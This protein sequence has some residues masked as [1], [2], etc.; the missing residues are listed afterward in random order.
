MSWTT[1]L[2]QERKDGSQDD[3]GGGFFWDPP[4]SKN[5]D[6]KSYNNVREL[7][8]RLCQATVRA[9]E[10]EMELEKYRDIVDKKEEIT[11]GHQ[12][13]ELM[14]TKQDMV[15]RIIQIGEKGR[16]AER[17]MKKLQLDESAFVNDFRAAISKLNS[18]EQINLVRCALNALEL[19]NGACESHDNNEKL[20]IGRKKN[21]ISQYNHIEESANINGVYDKRETEL[22]NKIQKLEEENKSLSVS[23]DELDQQHAQSIEKI[24]TL[25]DELQKKHQCLQVAYETLYV[26]Y[27]AIQEKIKMLENESTK[28][29]ISLEATEQNGTIL[30][31]KLATEDKNNQ[32]EQLTM[33][34]KINQIIK[35]YTDTEVQ[36]EDN[37]EVD[38]NVVLNEIAQKVNEIIKNTHIHL[39]EGETIFEA[40]AKHCIEAEWKIDMLER[41]L[42][43]LSSELR[44]TNEIRDSLQM[45][46]DEQQSTIESLE[47]EIQHMKSNLPSIPEASEE[48]VATLEVETESMAQEIKRLQCEYDTLRNK[49]SELITS[50]SNMEGSLRNQENLEAE[51]R[52]IKQQLEIAQQQLAGASKNVENNENMMED[53]SRRLHSSLDENTELR[54]K[55]DNLESRDKQMQEELNVYIEKCKGL[56]ENLELIEELKL[57]INNVRKELKNSAEN[58]KRLEKELAFADDAKKEIE[59]DILS[60]SQEKEQLEMEFAML[61]KCGSV[62]EDSEILKDL[63]SQLESA[64]REKDDLEYDLMNMR[65]EL[66]LALS[67][68][69]KRD[70][71]CNEL[72]TENE[73][74]IKENNIVLEQMGSVTNEW[75]ERLELLQTE[76]NLLQQEHSIL[77]EEATADKLELAEIR[78][79]TEQLEEKSINIEKNFHASKSECEILKSDCEN[80]RSRANMVTELESELQRMQIIENKLVASANETE[81]LKQKLISLQDESNE[82]TVIREKY[83][84]LKEQ[85]KN[86]RDLEEKLKNSENRCQ[87]LEDQLAVLTSDHQNL[88]TSKLTDE[89][90]QQ[91]RKT[92]EKKMAELELLIEEK[93]QLSEKLIACQR[94]LQS[95]ID[96]SKE[97]A[98][99]AKETI[100]TLSQIIK[101]KDQEI[102][103]VKSTMASDLEQK[104]VINE[105][106]LTSLNVERDELVKL[107]QIKHNESLQYHA[108]IQR[109]TQLFNDQASALQTAVAERESYENLLKQKEA[110]ILWGQNELQVVRQRLKNFE[111][112]MNHG[113]TCNIVEHSIQ[114]SQVAVLNEK[115]NAMEA[116]L[117]K[118]QSSNR[119]LQSQLTDSQQRE[120]AAA[121][122]L[123]RLRSHLVEME[124]NYTEEALLIEQSKKELETKLLQAEETL[125]NSS[126]VY[127]SA[128][129]RANQ[130]V[131][132][133]QQQMT[134][135][136][137]QRDEIQNKL[138]IAEDKVLRH[139]ASLMNLQIVLEQ[140]QRDKESDIQ[141]ATSKIREQLKD[142]HKKQEELNAE[143]INL[144]EQL[145]EAKECLLAASRLSQQ[146]N[147]KSERIQE[148]NDEVAKLTELV[149]TAEQR[150]EEAKQ[151]GEGKVD[152][153][154]IKNLLLGFLASS[155]SDKLSV[156][157]VFATVLDFNE[158]ERDK[159]GL[160]HP[161]AHGGWFSGLLSSGGT[162]TKDQEASLSAA[163]VRFLESES[164]P[165]PPIPPL[166]ISNTPISRPGHSRQHSSSSTQSGLLLSNMS[167]PSFPD[168]IPSRNTGS[169]LKE[170]L[171]DS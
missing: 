99:M 117:I 161:T 94:D 169:I 137:Q 146:L 142:S 130:Q 43:G 102:E 38:N 50:M 123:E 55:I 115:C 104:M 127:T 92:L 17:N 154:L 57:D 90:N 67:E 160:N 54:K 30:N 60:L 27:N 140:F 20:D 47:M 74:L 34:K 89:E 59:R 42:T 51:V 111:E 3:E 144:K 28:E 44:D 156:L 65:K 80:L 131:E 7:E 48:R 36:T 81:E 96:N 100:E 1:R 107:V 114:I 86:T 79:K 14:R 106:N 18:S 49:N 13:A 83:L 77:Q 153:S 109:M 170:V 85:L 148:L 19:E 88:L 11:D 8:E 95:A 2:S 122:E 72:I 98:D 145:A 10:L 82:L 129:I 101:Q 128:N 143:I 105:S 41:Q 110:D 40:T 23:I 68:S 91:I 151:S 168:F 108:E 165:M 21:L 63:R 6:T 35:N 152:K 45:D 134:L 9:R 167:L 78:R 66:D 12:K 119:I 32:T 84:N 166:P 136:I 125:K 31:L 29:K 124:E 93:N 76:M 87:Q 5:R 15:N 4:P 46:F 97:S 162:P 118:E 150:I 159:A 69:S 103:S 58:T 164:K 22:Q 116:A 113:E 71:L 141:N 132:T 138:S 26:D 139:A 52:N 37:N 158:M 135:I 24:L 39:E 16:E 73:R 126:T 133:L 112:S 64:N 147:K 33:E 163:F 120:S 53:L 171:K 155:N 75:Q 56:D 61:K 25:K 70:S 157:R 121:K 149:N 62:D